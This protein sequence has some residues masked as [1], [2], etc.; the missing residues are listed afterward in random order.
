MPRRSER[1]QRIAESAASLNRMRKHCVLL[2]A[3]KASK[4]MLDNFCD[5]C[6]VQCTNHSKLVNNRCL[7]PRNK[8]R[9]CKGPSVF[10]RHLKGKVGRKYYFN[11]KEF[12]RT[13]RMGRE[14]FKKLCNEIAD[15]PNF[16]SGK[17][18]DKQKKEHVREHLLHFLNFIGTFGDGSSNEHSRAKYEKGSGTCEN[19]RNRIMD[20]IIDNMKDKCY[21]WPDTD[22]RKDISHQIF[23]KYE[24][25]NCLGFIDGTLFPL[26]F[27]PRREDCGDYYGRKMGYSLSVLFACDHNLCIRYFNAGWPGSTHD[28]RVFRNCDVFKNK[29]K[30]FSLLEY[31]L[32]DSAHA[33]KNFLLAAYEKPIGRAI[34]EEDVLFNDMMKPARARIEHCIGLLKNRFQMLKSVRFVLNEGQKSMEKTIKHITCC[35]ILHNFLIAENDE[36]NNYFNED[37]DCVSEIDADNELNCPANDATNEDERR[38]QLTS[39]F[40]EMHM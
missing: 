6:S 2:A 1:K 31:S 15:H 5:V 24:F 26:Y 40:A 29:E 32:G 33:N 25:P 10:I 21:C 19:Y 14:T 34:S 38:Q 36:G 17:K 8:N 16:T 22:E 37:D 12:L 4:Q 7:K 20:A 9:M 30:Y 18:S 28:D 3:T 23:Q 35:V 27:K 39:Y 13:H 11:D